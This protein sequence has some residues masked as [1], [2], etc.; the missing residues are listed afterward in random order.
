VLLDGRALRNDLVLTDLFSP[1]TSFVS[2]SPIGTG[3][4]MFVRLGVITF[5]LTHATY[6]R[7]GL[8]GKKA[9]D[10]HCVVIRE[11]QRRDLRRIRPCEPIEGILLTENISVYQRFVKKARPVQFNVD[12]WAPAPKFAFDVGRF[13][14][15]GPAEKVDWRPEFCA[16]VDRC[17]LERGEVVAVSNVQRITIEG[18]FSLNSL[19]GWIKEVGMAGWSLLMIWDMV[20][21]PEVPV[22]KKMTMRGVGGGCDIVLF[23]A[24]LPLAVRF[25]TINYVCDE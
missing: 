14:T 7:F 8:T 5:T 20:D 6:Q 13:K 2:L 9:G 12:F 24:E 17:V 16:A 10:L 21:I 19:E 23:G 18:F 25:Q 15:S 22:G 11:D 4:G 1:S 3:N